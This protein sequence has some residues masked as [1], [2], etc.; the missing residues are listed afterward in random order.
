MAL[1]SAD[2]APVGPAT[3]REWTGLAVL[4][5]PTAMVSSDIG[6]LFLA[7]PQLGAALQAG[8][9]QL[10][11][12]T[13]VYG[14]LIAGCLITMGS[15]GDRI[16]R[17][18]LLM[19]GTSAFAVLSVLA[20]SAPT[21]EVLIGVRGL[22][23]IVG[24]TLMPSTLALI[25]TMFGD[26]RQRRRA[27]ALWMGCLM[28]G[29]T[30]G[31]VLG[32]VLLEHFWWGSVFLPAVPVALLVLVTGSVVLPED[33]GTGRGALDVT[34]VGLSL[35]AVLPMVY[36]VKE[37]AAHG[38]SAVATALPAAVVGVGCA[39]TFTRRQRR[40]V[41]PLLD[42]RP[43]AQ[44][45]FRIVAAIG[46]VTAATTGGLFLVFSQYI[47]MAQPLSPLRAGLWLTPAALAMAAGSL[48]APGL[49]RRGQV[50]SVLAACLAAAA[51]GSLLLSRADGPLMAAVAIAVIH[52]GLG[53]VFT[54]TTD[55]IVASAPP[56]RSGSAAAVSETT[57]ELGLAL[58][59]AVLGSLA[60][61]VHR[62]ALSAD[63]PSATTTEAPSAAGESLAAAVAVVSAR[64][65][66][67]AS[68]ELIAAIRDAATSGL[69]ATAACAAVVLA[70]LALV[71]ATRLRPFH[72][73]RVLSGRI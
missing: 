66:T 62:Q 71:A 48:L 1:R 68:V 67:A 58:G 34:S 15:L 51:A 16:G 56:E 52:G 61:A 30:L 37:L 64:P 31:P 17:R 45:S 60:T 46:L 20:A 40:L 38:W 59:V 12:I 70:G 49:L 42:L 8:S 73:T 44:R 21:A 39:V 50:H 35:T 43:F 14:F 47:Q 6:V 41:T 9:T 55:L 2:L 10:L 11:W 63:F 24:A 54:A 53:P 57:S 18:R 23:G 33:R 4:A 36:A 22:L 69:S 7:L 72:V 29:A 32:G 28:A 5:L 13:D 27:I 19:V 25:S 26:P 65:D 3:R